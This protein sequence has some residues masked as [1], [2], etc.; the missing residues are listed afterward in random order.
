VP[1]GAAAP[2]RVSV[3]VPTHDTRELTLRCLASLARSGADELIVVDDGSRDGST[4]AIRAAHPQAT[5]LEF[6]QARGFSA[7]ANTGLARASGDLLWLVNSDT[8]VPTGAAERLRAIFARRPRLGVASPQL[9]NPDGTRQWTGARWPGLLWLFALG[10]GLPA[11]LARLRGGLRTA[12]APARVEWVSGAAMVIRAE[13]WQQ[14]GALDE[15]FGFYGQ[16]L[17]LC[18]RLA[19]AGWEVDLLPEVEVMH[20][21]GVSIG[22]R[23]GALRSMHPELLY[24]DLVRCVARHRGAPAGR[25][26]ACVLRVGNRLRL[27]MRGLLEPLVAGARRSHW[28]R[29][30]AALVAAQRALKQNPRTQ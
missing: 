6:A 20:V 21:G 3:V 5:V 2:L 10:T 16:D 15:G 14:A 7:A 1:A 25:R 18:W 8:E 9:V 28:K 23:E 30:S 13:A 26:A 29:E 22:Q 11:R 24:C 27:M 19:R 12:T 4:E 17:D